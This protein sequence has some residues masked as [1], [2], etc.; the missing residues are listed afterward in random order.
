MSR[1]E[2]AKRSSETQEFSRT[3]GLVN[4]ILHAYINQAYNIARQSLNDG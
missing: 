2:T 3:L 1:D 4:L